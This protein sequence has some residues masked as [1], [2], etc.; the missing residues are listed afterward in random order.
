MLNT[1]TFNIFNEL[2]KVLFIE[3][4]KFC[5]GQFKFE[6]CQ[7]VILKYKLIP[8]KLKA[9]NIWTFE[10]FRTCKATNVAKARL[11]RILYSRHGRIEYTDIFN[12][13]M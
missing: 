3:K 12:L 11:D 4:T 2:I 10:F 7:I 5:S 1:P 9:E 8:L 13:R 6:P